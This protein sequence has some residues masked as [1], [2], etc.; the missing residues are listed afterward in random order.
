MRRIFMFSRVIFSGLIL[1]LP[2]LATAQLTMT[3]DYGSVVAPPGQYSMRFI[4]MLTTPSIALG[5]A[6]LQVGANN[7][8]TG[9]LAGAANATLSIYNSGPSATFARPR[10]YGQAT[11]FESGQRST[12][13]ESA[14]LRIQQGFRFGV[15]TF[16]GGFG[17]ARLMAG[18]R[19]LGRATHA[20]TNDDIARLDKANEML[21]PRK[22][23]RTAKEESGR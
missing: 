23:A 18:Q 6:P 2:A 11:S 15:A 16:E 17:V 20:Y 9:N 1:L 13:A 8:T 14:D 22:D 10:W 7:A 4:P 3:F 21:G 19:Y 5:S 12:S